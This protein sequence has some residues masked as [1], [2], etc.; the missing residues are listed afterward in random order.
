MNELQALS[1]PRPAIFKDDGSLGHYCCPKCGEELA[2][3]SVRGDQAI[4]MLSRNYVKIKGVWQHKESTKENPRIKRR[5]NLAQQKSIRHKTP[6]S[7]PE[8]EA[9]NELLRKNG[10]KPAKEPGGYATWKIE[11]VPVEEDLI[12]E[13][14]YCRKHLANLVRISYNLLRSVRES[15]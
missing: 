11:F 7:T 2:Y 15:V 10:I 4:F 13:C 12:V 8:L 9:H 1:R 3:N 5:K 14:R 6:P